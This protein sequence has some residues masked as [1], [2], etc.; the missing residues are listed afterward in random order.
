MGIRTSDYLPLAVLLGIVILCQAAPASAQSPAS[1]SSTAST[2]LGRWLDQK[3]MTGYW[4]GARTTLED[5][6]FNP[7]AHFIT[8]SAA[9]PIGGISQSAAYTQQ[10]D[11]GFDL[12]LGKIA[13]IPGGRFQ[14]TL[15]DRA[16]Q[17]LTNNA[18]G[19]LFQVQELYGAGQNFRLAE[20]NYQQDLFNKKLT[21]QIGWSPVGDD[22]ATSPLYCLFQNGVICG[23]NNAMTQNSGAHNFP[24]GQWG[25]HV[26]V[27]P[28][29][30]YYVAAGVYDTNPDSGNANAGFDLRYR[31]GGVF[32]PVE[33]GWMPGHNGDE[34]PGNYKIGAYYNSGPT[35]DVL[36]DIHGLS[37]G[38]TRLPF[39][40][41]AGRWGGYIM[42]DQMVYRERAGSPRGLTVGAIGGFGD[43]DTAK[44]GYFLSTG[45]VYQGTFPGR[46]YDSIAFMVAYAHINNRLTQFQMDRNVVKPGS[47]GIQTYEGIL[48]VDYG[49]QLSPWLSLHPNLQYIIN[50]GGTGTIPNAFVIGLTTRLTL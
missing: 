30:E 37:A 28:T 38:F 39:G 13:G 22:F 12:D 4:G 44:Y 48:E 20:M 5:A 18:I 46:D 1:E 23:H 21:F 2:M 17:S 24:T 45:G 27:R 19:N 9:N 49:L 41:D 25:A 15:V 36:S 29:P 10:I 40:T 11:F 35:P 16:G 6:G 3:T 14:F 8:E 47:V 31:G 34:L 32:T 43:P 50:P 33:V 42:V 26:K 7:R